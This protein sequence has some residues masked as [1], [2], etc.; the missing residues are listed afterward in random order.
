LVLAG[1][2]C[3]N[4]TL[5]ALYSL[6]AAAAGFLSASSDRGEPAGGLAKKDSGHKP[7]LSFK[8]GII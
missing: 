3:A 8:G 7:N 5:P 6:A 4:R 2:N 1:L